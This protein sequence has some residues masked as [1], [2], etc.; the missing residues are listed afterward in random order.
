MLKALIRKPVGLFVLSWLIAAVV[1]LTMLTIRWRTHN[2]E[3]GKAILDDHDGFI[4][5][6][7]HSRIIAMPWLWPRRHAMNALQ[8]PHPDGRLLAHT[9]NHLGVRTVWGSS[10]R[11]AMSGLRGL[12]RI[13]DVGK[14]AA[15]TPDGPRG[16]ARV[17]ATGPVALANLTEKP[18]IP[19]AWAVDRFWRAPGWDSMIIPKPFCRGIMIWGDALQPESKTAGSR[20]NGDKGNRDRMES[21]RKGL[22]AALNDVTDRADR[23]FKGEAEADSGKIMTDA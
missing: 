9:V 22:E 20:K 13:L 6:F 2:P 1:A 14:V 12:K 7:W 19:V 11:N 17:C 15:I 16:P 23:Y 3:N 18:I 8:S 5:V 21:Q 4:L 10:N